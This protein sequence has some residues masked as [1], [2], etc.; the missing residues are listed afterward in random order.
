VFSPSVLHQHE[1]QLKGVR[2]FQAAA[3]LLGPSVLLGRWMGG[4]IVEAP[5]SQQCCLCMQERDIFLMSNS[6]SS[7][8][9]LIASTYAVL[10]HLYL[11]SMNKQ[12]WAEAAPDRHLS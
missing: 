10:C 6:Y 4:V 5:L 7:V 2:S 8:F 3:L 9:H 1:M 11:V 12:R